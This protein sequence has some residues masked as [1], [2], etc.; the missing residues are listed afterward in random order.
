[1]SNLLRTVKDTCPTYCTM[2]KINVQLTAQCPR[3]MSNLLHI[4]QD[5]CPTYCTMSKIHVQLS[6]QCPRYI[7]Q[8]TTHCPRYM[9]NLLHNVQDT[10][11]TY[12]TIQF[13]ESFKPA[14]MYRNVL[15]F[16]ME[17]L[18]NKQEGVIIRLFF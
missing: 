13:L 8:L 7:V 4:V 9:S 2:S 3:Y 17:K 12:C 16:K 5:T 11:P 15:N 18:I 6:A 1:M 10:C 14:C